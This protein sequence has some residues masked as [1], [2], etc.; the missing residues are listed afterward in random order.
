MRHT[1]Y[2][3]FFCARI[4]PQDRRRIFGCDKE[5]GALRQPNAA[6]PTHP[7]YCP[8]DLA[9]RPKD[10]YRGALL[11]NPR[12]PRAATFILSNCRGFA[13]LLIFRVGANVRQTLVFIEGIRV[14]RGTDGNLP[15]FGI[16]A[17]S[18]NPGETVPSG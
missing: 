9:P 17:A 2:S 3:L 10:R 12:P 6:R 16:H 4:L 13:S 11:L 15:G 5:N 18:G 14:R 8:T 7:P 1:S